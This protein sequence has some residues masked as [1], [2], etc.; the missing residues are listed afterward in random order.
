[1]PY[2]GPGIYQHYKGPY[3][4]VL[5]LGVHE[6]HKD[7]ARGFDPNNP[8]LQH[9]IYRP[10]TPGSL[11]DGSESDF[12][13]RHRE[14]FDGHVPR[15][16]VAVPRFSFRSGEQPLISEDGSRITWNGTTYFSAKVE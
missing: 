13:I 8:L 4:Q 3:Y 12:W 6:Y 7:N 10:M 16:D 11:L 15:V 9:A 2:Q 5:G 14:D 1:M